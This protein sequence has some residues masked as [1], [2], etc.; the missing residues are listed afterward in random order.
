MLKYKNTA[1]LKDLNEVNDFFIDINFDKKKREYVKVRVADKEALI[2]K[3]D[4]YLVAFAI[5]DETIQ[6]KL[7]PVKQ[8]NVVEHTR[9]IK[10]KATKDIK[11][12]ETITANITYEVP[13]SIV[14]YL[15]A[16]KEVI[17]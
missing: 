4:L 7:L 16:K 5:A 2:D 8:V 14:E 1:K 11:K 10:F 6:E 13:K 12:G 3:Q 9:A 15:G 17:E